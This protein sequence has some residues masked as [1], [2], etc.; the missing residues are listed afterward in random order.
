MRFQRPLPPE[1]LESIR[2]SAVALWPELKGAR[3]FIA[4]A[5]GFFGRWLIESLLSADARYGLGVRITALSRDPEAFLNRA[6]H[7]A[8]A[9][10]T[11]VKGSVATLAP[12]LF[13]GE[14][15]DAVVHLA[16][17]GDLDASTTHPAAMVGV[18]TGGTRRAL[19]VAVRCGAK[20]FLFTSSGA[21][22]GKQPANVEFMAESYPG[23]P[24]LTDLQNPYAHPG[25]A[26]R[27]AELLCVEAARRDGLNAVIARGFTFAGPGLP[28]D[29]KFAF[30]NFIRDA[31]A[32]G[33]IVIKG[34][35]T[36][37]RS[38]LHAIDLTVWLWTLLMKGRSGRA[39]NVGS[40]KPVA[41]LDLARAISREFG[42]QDIKV[43]GGTPV[44]GVPER[45]VP[46][47][48]R[49]R[50]ELGLSETL[51][52]SEIVRRTAAWHRLALKH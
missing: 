13:S 46:S 47:T 19:D 27:Q 9:G 15:F 5:T 36:P 33:P 1:D 14:K 42:N 32:G 2:L 3:I 8:G 45:Y 34:D 44:A 21:V 25:E 31:I 10:L 20:R 38:Y 51:E 40:E 7:L 28:P 11:W 49:A 43:L 23:V 37:I 22:Y 39:Y 50:D 30:G 6:P 12:E 24:D 26:K 4:G 52:L 48:L 41:M 18:I 35:G 17:E 16:T 29:S